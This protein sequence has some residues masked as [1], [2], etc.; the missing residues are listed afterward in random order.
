ML[1]LQPYLMKTYK[2]NYR[3]PKRGLVKLR[4]TPAVEYYVAIRKVFGKTTHNVNEC[5]QG[6]NESKTAQ[7]NS[8]HHSLQNGER[9]KIGKNIKHEHGRSLEE[10]IMGAIYFLDWTLLNL[11]NSMHFHN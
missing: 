9:I 5:P 2:M 3:S 4:C 10:R 7:S 1:L 8:S 11:P 6:H